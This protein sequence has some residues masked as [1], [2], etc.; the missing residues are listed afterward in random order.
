MIDSIKLQLRDL[1]LGFW[2]AL[3]LSS[4]IIALLMIFYKENTIILLA[5]LCGIFYI[6]FAG[7]GKFLCFIFGLL[8]C[9]LY[10]YVSYKAQLYGE[11]LLTFLYIPLNLLGI[12]NWIKNQNLSKTK[13]KIQ[14]L[15]N[16]Q[17]SLYL[18]LLIFVSI[19]Y[20]IFLEKIDA[21]FPFL[22][23]FSTIA[24][25]IAFYLQIHRYKENYLIVTFANIIL[26]YIWLE[27]FLQNPIYLAQT[28]NMFLFLILGIFYYFKWNQEAKENKG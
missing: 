6:F 15:N 26:C 12:F 1:S 13:I 14:T 7:Q 16:L 17:I 2:I 24:Q 9:I 5:S 19:F 8:Y 3:L 18:L 28:L 25:I 10:A 21:K 27:L 11:M 20:G 4:L 22:N 23:A